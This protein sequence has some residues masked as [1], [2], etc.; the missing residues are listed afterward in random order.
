M[1]HSRICGV[2]TKGALSWCVTCPAAFCSLE[3]QILSGKVGHSIECRNPNYVDRIWTATDVNIFVKTGYKIGYGAAGSVWANDDIDST[4]VIKLSAVR[5]SCRKYETDFQIAKK[6]A[7]RMKKYGF[8]NPLAC[9]IE[10]FAEIPEVIN[11]E[12]FKHCAL[13]MQRVFRPSNLPFPDE[14][15]SY[16]AYLG[17]EDWTNKHAFRGIY[18][19]AEQIEPAIQPKTLVELASAMGNLIG[20]LHYGARCDASDMEYLLGK[21]EAREDVQVGVMAVDFDQVKF[22]TRQQM[23]S[24]EIRE[25]FNWSIWQESYFPHNDNVTLFPAFE[26]AYLKQAQRFGYL[27]LAEEVLQ[28]E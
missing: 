5:E 21:P 3:C 20:F 15:Q 26:E 24:K 22:Y 18:L 14:I 1:K 17:E 6:I 13:V 23:G 16:H 4:V 28:E 12:G 8:D 10:V 11:E 2:C 27:R 25:K 9:V 19:G 7:R